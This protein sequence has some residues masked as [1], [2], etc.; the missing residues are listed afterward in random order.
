VAGVR[1]GDVTGS[2]GYGRLGDIP[3]I[4][5]GTA[6]CSHAETDLPSQLSTVSESVFE[7]SSGF[8]RR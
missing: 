7:R 4:D 8:L 1:C 2:Y 5:C 6:V 3:S